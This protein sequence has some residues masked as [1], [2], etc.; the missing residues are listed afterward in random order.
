MLDPRHSTAFTMNDKQIPPFINALDGILEYETVRG[1]EIEKSDNELK[2]I[3]IHR[4]PVEDGEPIFDINEVVAI[5][6]K[7]AQ[8]VGNHKGLDS[9]TT[10]GESEIHR[11]QD[12]G[13]ME[14]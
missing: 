13:K 11:L 6:Q 9:I 4:I 5:Q 3:F 12:E 14:K 8:I 2:S 1:N 7:I 10:F